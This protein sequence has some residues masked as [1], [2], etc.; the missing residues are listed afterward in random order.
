MA[1]EHY[2]AL[3]SLLG[4]EEM[5]VTVLPKAAARA[6]PIWPSPPRP[7]TPTRFPPCNG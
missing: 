5:A 4:E 3:S 6:T 7:T 1:I 2:L